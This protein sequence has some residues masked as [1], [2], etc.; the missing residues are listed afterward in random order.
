MPALSKRM[1]PILASFYIESVLAV[2]SNTT[3][4]KKKWDF[5]LRK[6]SMWDSK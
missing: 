4:T 2:D 3:K 6:Y 5:N 1:V